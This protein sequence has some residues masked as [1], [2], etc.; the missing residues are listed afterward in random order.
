MKSPVM[1]PFGGG[2]QNTTQALLSAD[3]LSL[4]HGRTC[5]RADSAASPPTT[6]SSF[7]PAASSS[8]Q[9]KIEESAARFLRCFIG[10]VQEEEE[11][12]KKKKKQQ[13]EE[14]IVVALFLTG[15]DFAEWRMSLLTFHSLFFS[16]SFFFGLYIFIHHFSFH[17]TVHEPQSASTQGRRGFTALLSLQSEHD[18][19]IPGLVS[20]PSWCSPGGGGGGGGSNMYRGY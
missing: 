20:H 2:N 17:C 6:T 12:V 11:G 10:E 1:Y 8:P 14:V 16:F 13:G 18:N 3:S 9:Q 5:P 15:G 19:S 7:T 4:F